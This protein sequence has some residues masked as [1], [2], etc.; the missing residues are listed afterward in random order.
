M[1]IYI[2]GI[3]SIAFTFS[4]VTSSSDTKACLVIYSDTSIPA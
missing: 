1:A 3:C 4:K 2:T